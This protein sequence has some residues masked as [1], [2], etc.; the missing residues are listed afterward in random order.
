[1]LKAGVNYCW[2]CRFPTQSWKTRRQESIIVQT[3]LSFNFIFLCLKIL[4]AIWFF[5]L[6]HRASI[7]AVC[8]VATASKRCAHRNFVLSCNVFGYAELFISRRTSCQQVGHPPS[9]SRTGA[10]LS[11]LLCAG[12]QPSLQG[13]SRHSSQAGLSESQRICWKHALILFTPAQVSGLM[14]EMLDN[15]FGPCGKGHTFYLCLFTTYIFLNRPSDIV[16]NLRLCFTLSNTSC[17]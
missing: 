11:H 5:D 6:L 12:G 3:G 14:R 16:Q 7:L 10:F 2:W 4:T 17:T 13:W 8:G 15:G 9:S 1:V